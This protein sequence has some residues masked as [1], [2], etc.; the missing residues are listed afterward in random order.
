M[1]A[2]DYWPLT[3]DYSIWNAT[4]AALQ[5]WTADLKAHVLSS[6]KEQVYNAFF[7][8]TS[9]HLLCQQSEGVLFGHFVTMRHAAF[10][11]KLTLEDE[12]YESGSESFNIPTPL[13]STPKIHHVSSNDISFDPST[14]CST[15]TNQSYCKPVCHWLSFNSS[16]DE[17]SL[18]VDSSPQNLPDLAQQPDS[19]CIYT[20]CDDLEEE[21][22]EEEEDFQTVTLDDAHWTM[23][24]IQDRHLC[25]HKHS[26]PHLLCHFPCPYVAYTST[27][28]HNTLDFS[29]ISEFEDLMTTSSDEDIPALDDEIG[30]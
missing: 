26:V 7:Y 10:E 9:M 3:R 28:Y 8:I 20:I 13:R 18:A 27:L 15:V 14:P 6:A 12:G 23:E 30:Y 22:E 24:E 21:D 1:N 29:D 16:E 11:S 2:T 25:I 19:K 17:E 4:V 5:I